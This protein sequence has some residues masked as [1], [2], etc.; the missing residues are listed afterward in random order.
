[1]TRRIIQ[2]KDGP[3]A[4]GAYSQA[5]IDGGFLFSAGQIAID[6]AV[7][8]LIDGDVRA[9]AAQVM[10]NLRAILQAAGCDF[11]DVVKTTIYITQMADFQVVNAAYAEHFTQAP[12]ARSTV[13]V[14]ELPLGALV[15]IDVVA[16]CES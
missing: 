16:R 7:G 14:R 11:G 4:V 3:Q 2:T 8:K 6:P 15:E 13:A 12:P 5:V 1:M 9:Q 10:R